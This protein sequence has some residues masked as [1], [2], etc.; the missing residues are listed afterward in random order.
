MLTVDNCRYR[1]AGR[2]AGRQAYIYC[3]FA[4]T[5]TPTHMTQHTEK[6]HKPLPLQSFLPSFLPACLLTHLPPLTPRSRRFHRTRSCTQARPRRPPRRHPHPCA[7][8]VA[9]R[10]K[11]DLQR[12][13]ITITVGQH[14]CAYVRMNVCTCPCNGYVTQYATGGYRIQVHWH[15]NES[16][17]KYKQTTSYMPPQS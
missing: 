14:A 15:K 11:S 1:Q 16:Q 4:D 8:T 5:H 13:G 17:V 6:E 12:I 2:Q 7:R 10:T 3:A 9:P